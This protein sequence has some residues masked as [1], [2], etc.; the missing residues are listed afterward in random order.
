MK[1]NEEA[2]SKVEASGYSKCPSSQRWQ[3]G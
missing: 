2:V 1:I 3:L